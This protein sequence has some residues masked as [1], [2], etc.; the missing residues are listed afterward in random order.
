MRTPR[1]A[2]GSFGLSFKFCKKSVIGNVKYI[3]PKNQILV[4]VS[5][6]FNTQEVLKQY[7][8]F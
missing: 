7:I 4:G 8:F 3:N 6:K 2:Q 1:L 5:L